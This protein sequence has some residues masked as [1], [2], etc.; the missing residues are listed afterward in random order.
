VTVAPFLPQPGNLFL[1]ADLSFYWREPDDLSN[2]VAGCIDAIQVAYDTLT[3][4]VTAFGQ[5][6]LP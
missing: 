4:D 1:Q 5:E 2:D 6:F 3:A